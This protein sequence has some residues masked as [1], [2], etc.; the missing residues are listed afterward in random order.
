MDNDGEWL[1]DWRKTLRV[2]VEVDGKKVCP[3]C[4]VAIDVADYVT[5]IKTHVVQRDV[6]LCP[7]DKC[8]TFLK[9][10][11]GLIIRTSRR[12]DVISDFREVGDEEDD[13][14]LDGEDLISV[15]NQD[16][17]RN[18]V[19]FYTQPGTKLHDDTLYQIPNFRSFL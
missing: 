8:A 5:H 15:L 4:Q 12:S 7:I 17:K 1:P 19:A 9:E 14:S 16:F 13:D 10:N 3:K 2:A 18:A 11:E 6:P